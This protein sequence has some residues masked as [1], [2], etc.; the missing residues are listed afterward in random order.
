[1]ALTLGI[2]DKHRVITYHSIYSFGFGFT[3]HV[4]G[5]YD[6][7][8]VSCIENNISVRR[9][10]FALFADEFAFFRLR[11][12]ADKGIVGELR[13]RKH[14][15]AVSD[16][17]LCGRIDGAA[18]GIKCDGYIGCLPMSIKRYISANIV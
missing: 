10:V 7:A 13:L 6:R 11:V 16:D 2:T 3:V 12:P 17:L 1:M 18:A 9:V 15:A 8:T 5:D 14:H 4:K